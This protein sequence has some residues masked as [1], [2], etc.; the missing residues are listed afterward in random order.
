MARCE[1]AERERFGLWG[2]EGVPLYTG[3]LSTWISLG[4]GQEGPDTPIKG[5]A[6]IRQA[7]PGVLWFLPGHLS[8][9]PPKLPHV[10]G[11]GSV[12]TG[13]PPGPA[14]T[15]HFVMDGGGR[16]EVVRV[17]P[18]RAGPPVTQV[19]VL[20]REG[21]PGQSQGHGAGGE[22]TGGDRRGTGTPALPA[23]ENILW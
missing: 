13:S 18:G 7:A 16:R 4:N 22:S 15:Y 21:T 8:E 2:S 6:P 5:P 9:D 17:H 11:V 1:E 14:G 3:G 19:I 12:V 23:W 10:P 20:R